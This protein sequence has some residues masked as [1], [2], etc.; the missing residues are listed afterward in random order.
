M[1]VLC[2]ELTHYF[3]DDKYI[4]SVAQRTTSRSITRDG[5]PTATSCE[6]SKHESDCLYIISTDDCTKSL[7]YCTKTF[8]RILYADSEK[9]ITYYDGKYLTYSVDEWEVTAEHPADEIKSGS[10]YTFETC[11]DYIFVFD[12]NSGEL[13][14]TIDIT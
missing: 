5:G 8:E 12:D 4:V 10:S 1:R 6:M 7:Q 3:T 2:V 13:L 11:G 9:A 14:N